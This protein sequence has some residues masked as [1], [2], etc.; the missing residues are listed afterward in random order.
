MSQYDVNIP[1]DLQAADADGITKSITADE[2]R[3]P[4]NGALASIDGAILPVSGPIFINSTGDD[5]GINFT[6]SGI[7]NGEELSEVL[8]GAD[9]GTAQSVNSYDF[10]TS[11][12]SDGATDG[13]IT[14][15][16]TTGQDEIAA[17]QTLA[18]DGPVSIDG[19]YASA[20]SIPSLGF[21]CSPSITFSADETGNIFTITGT[22]PNGVVESVQ[23]AGT[24]PSTVNASAAFSSI[25]S[26]SCSQ[27]CA[28]NITVGIAQQTYSAWVPIDGQRDFLAASA[29]VLFGSAV[30]TATLEY[31][32]FSESNNVNSV[33]LG[34]VEDTILNAVSTNTGTPINNPADAVRLKIPSWTSGAIAFVVRQANSGHA[35][36]GN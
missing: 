35:A 21:A 1:I 30:A 13:N 6:I 9:T 28:G 22:N 19:S 29:F 26:V 15:G 8:P 11:I 14:V 2:G 20:Q 24:T 17:A 23:V 32:L 16:Y 25:T 10:I 34:T 12:D 36:Q 5:S 31:G 18:G 27:A 3:I 33:L 7:L 4:L